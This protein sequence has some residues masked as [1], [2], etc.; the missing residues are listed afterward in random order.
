MTSDQFN[1]TITILK[2]SVVLIISVVILFAYTSV[3]MPS[4]AHASCSAG[5]GSIPTSIFVP[6]Y[7]YLECDASGAPQITNWSSAVPLVGL[8]IISLLMRV[9]GLV[10]VGFIIWG[11]I[12]YTTSQGSPE[13]AKNAK[14]TI[15]NAVIG[16]VITLIAIGLVQFVAGLIK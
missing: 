13:G 2:A 12:Q 8:A 10:A 6:W 5:P 11:G 1:G 9:G 4:V 15:L 14:S 3:I 7:A 16:L